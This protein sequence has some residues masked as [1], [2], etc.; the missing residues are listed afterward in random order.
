M[1][2]LKLYLY[3]SSQEAN[4]YRGT[5]LSQY[6]IMGGQNNEDLTEVLDTSEITLLGYPIREAFAPETKMILDE[7]ED[8][9]VI[10]T[11]H[12]V[13]KEDLVNQPVMSNNSYFE[14]SLTLTEPSVV[15]QK[16]IVDNMAI[17]YKLKD[18]SLETQTSFDLDTP[19]GFKIEKSS[20]KPNGIKAGYSKTFIQQNA[21]IRVHSF[22]TFFFDS[23]PV[24]SNLLGDLTN[25]LKYNDIS[26]FPIAEDGKRY[27]KIKLPILFVKGLTNGETDDFTSTPVSM[28]YSVEA[29]EVGGLTTG[30]I[31]QSGIVYANDGELFSQIGA[32][33]NGEY[34]PEYSKLKQDSVFYT[35][36][37]GLN[38]ERELK[39]YTE[40]KRYINKTADNAT[41]TTSPFEVKDN[42]E[43]T[44]TC[45]LANL[46]GDSTI[47]NYDGNEI[48]EE[49][50]VSAA[51]TTRL[52]DSWKVDTVRKTIAPIETYTQ[53]AV[54]VTYSKPNINK[55]LSQGIPYTCLNLLKKAIMNSA[56][57]PR[58]ANAAA[59]E[60]NY[61]DNNGQLAYDCPFY[62]DD[63]FVEKLSTTQ[64]TEAFFNQKNLWEIM[65]EAGHY[66]HA[67]S[68]LRFGKN[69]K[70][71]LTFNELGAPIDSYVWKDK[72]RISITNFRGVD[73]YVCEINSYI[74]NCVQL[75]GQIV[76]W[77]AAKTTDSTYLVS[78]DT[79]ELVVSF[80]IIELLD[81][82]I[83]ANAAYPGIAIGATENATKYF[84]EKNIYQLLS[85]KYEDIPNK[86]ISMY[87]TLG[88]N[89]IVGGDYQLPRP[90]ADKWNDYAIKKIIYCAFN[91][92]SASSPGDWL[93]IKVNDFSFR[94]T[95]RTKSSVRQ[96]HTRPDV[97]KYL[98]ESKFDETP[99]HKQVANQTEVVVDSEKYGSNMYG[100]LIRTGNNEFEEVFWVTSPLDLREKGE[101]VYPISTQYPFYVA[102][103]ENQYYP[104]H[105]ES[106]ATYSQDYNE[107]SKI[108]G[109][110]SEP[111]FYEISEQSVIDRHVS[112]DDYL[113]LTTEANL[114]VNN[115]DG[116]IEDV[117]HLKNLILGS[118]EVD[119]A[120][121]VV[122][123]F[124]G[125]LDIGT[126]EGTFG[127][128]GFYQEI[129]SPLNAYNS[130]NTLTYSWA[131]AD[132]FSAGDKVGEVEYNGSSTLAD[133]AY[134]GLTA[135]QYTDKFG[136]AA[137]FD[138]FLLEDFSGFTPEQINALPESP[139]SAKV[140]TGTM[141]TIASEKILATN[142]DVN[143]TNYNRR[144]LIL[145]KDCRERLLFD[146]NIRLITDSD[147]FVTSPYVFSPKDSPLSLALLS[148]E[149]N[150]F[151]SGN[152]PT[153]SV[154]KTYTI[155]ANNI[156]EFPGT[157]V[158][159][160]T[161]PV[162]FALRVDQI[163]GDEW[164]DTSETAKGARFAAIALVQNYS[165]QTSVTR[166]TLARNIGWGA[167][168]NY[169]RKFWR[170]GVP[171]NA[172]FTKK[173]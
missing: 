106:K 89:K 37:G 156:Q 21:V 77:V 119:F 122:T 17:T 124:K 64:V 127:E 103:V 109:I 132:N 147:S 92:Y 152:I 168:K 43:Y 69:D 42:W 74:T 143:D 115:A 34:L 33:E 135:V 94:I 50:F 145:L 67:I 111:R 91:G 100:T 26:Q 137:L 30:T 113:L 123:A 169:A 38:Y 126:N 62:I 68:E 90:N 27:A 48:A 157:N 84:Y 138:F 65:I 28:Y 22:K 167:E 39:S 116:Y 144:G 18:V 160:Q 60:L 120:K 139:V 134:R 59:G 131:M 7:C 88:E 159:G 66:I 47:N 4:G 35:V 51:S 80:P 153:G 2:N 154:L 1:I 85:I 172:F 162:W 173:Q 57:K 93:N 166:F 117:S 44:V 8:D 151:A 164:F 56:L 87:Y 133:N 158:Y 78:N 25:T 15:A 163:I 3:D 118:A 110:P 73:D 98:V 23:I 125:D 104:N 29:R 105:I 20:G 97:R 146:Y 128:A 155:S 14:H 11:F 9:N 130:G 40:Y 101:V 81:V 52:A 148:K 36:T 19:S 75:G 102:K 12:R 129:M 49:F 108:I 142:V 31:I 141:P 63:A 150:K 45:R 71:L 170:F 99:Q 96:S 32:S 114:S 140:T 53:T 24:F 107:L 58:Q 10:R 171:E 70:F 61:V 149:V 5:D 72:N 83:K 13:V 161:K 76:E 55:L 6:L 165:P 112:I 79:A 16:R 82:T 136:K 41:Y 54:F 46:T 121:Y 95:Y 86:G